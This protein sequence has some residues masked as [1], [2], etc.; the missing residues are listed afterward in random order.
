VSSLLVVTGPPGAGK[1]TAASLL[2]ERFER[3]A[4]VE[5]DAFFAFLRRGAIAPWLPGSRAQNEA[6]TQAAGAA[7]GRFAAGGMATVYDGVVGPWFLP[8]FAAA[9]GLDR[10]D[11]VVLLPAVGRCVERVRSRTGHGFGDEA[12]T[13]KMHHEFATARIAGRHVLADP[14]EGADAVADLVAGALAAG[15][16]AF[17]T[18]PG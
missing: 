10:L 12:A 15:E 4:L 1:S 16:L 18:G 6:V 2:A 7:A 3:S 5:G 14:P 17:T 13:R 11:Y 9:T 8:V